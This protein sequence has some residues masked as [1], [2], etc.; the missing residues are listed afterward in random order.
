M[1]DITKRSTAAAQVGHNHDA[2]VT[3]IESRSV[4]KKTGN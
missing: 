2:V 3:Y 4:A 1:Q